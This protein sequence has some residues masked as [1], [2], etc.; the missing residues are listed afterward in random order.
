MCL[1]EEFLV[2]DIVVW[3]VQVSKAMPNYVKN[4]LC[5]YKLFLTTQY[6]AIQLCSIIW[7]MKHVTVWVALKM[8]T[9]NRDIFTATAEV[10]KTHQPYQYFLVSM[11]TFHQVFPI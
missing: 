3:L 5:I 7:R 1:L 2:F 4:E 11:R 8:A 10:V 6:G 9:E